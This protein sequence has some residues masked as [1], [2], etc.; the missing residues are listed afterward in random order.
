MGEE[1]R[2]KK[3]KKQKQ[4]VLLKQKTAESQK[5]LGLLEVLEELE[6]EEKYVDVQICPHCKS[7]R[8][9]RVGTMS[10]DM[11]GHMGLLPLKFEC[12]DCGWR[13]RLVVKATNRKLGLKE[14]AI[15]A[16]ALNLKRIVF[17][18]SSFLNPYNP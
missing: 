11:S 10:G 15:I 9:R 14:V 13:E 7:P 17:T 6:R 5:F 3:K 8:V 16:E 2:R 1:K 4:I 18:Y 12:L